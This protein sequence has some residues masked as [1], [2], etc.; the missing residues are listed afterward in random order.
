MLL[1]VEKLLLLEA[2]LQE[3][4]LIDIGICKIW[5]AIYDIRYVDIFNRQNLT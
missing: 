1:V 4:N 2:L 3:V 5:Y